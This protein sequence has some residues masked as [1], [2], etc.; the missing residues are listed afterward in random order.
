MVAAPTSGRQ[1]GVVPVGRALRRRWNRI[2]RRLRESELAP[3]L[4]LAS[5]SVLIGAGQYAAPTVVPLTALLIPLIIGNLVL[6]PRTLPWTVVFG[7]GVLVVVVAST[8]SLLDGRRIGGVVV[9]FL[10]GLII[11]VSSFRRTRLGVA[12]VRGESM[13]VDLRDRI[14]NQ[15]RMPELPPDWYAEVVLRSAGGSSFAGDFLVASRAEDGT[16][17]QVAVVDVSGKGEQAG[18]RS[19]LLSGAFGGLLGALPAERFLVAANDYLLRQDWSEGFATAVHAQ[20]DLRTGVFELR[21]AGHPPGVQMHAGSGRW[22]VHEAEG[23]VLGLMK[24]AEFTVVHGRVDRGDALLLF[25]DGVVETPQR[26]I[27][28]GIDKLLGLGEQLLRS[29]FEQ[30]AHR[31]LDRLGSMHDDDRALLLLHRR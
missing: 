27:S 16:S 6:S 23:P 4:L 1:T 18:S 31:L 26:D 25:T 14:H 22:E 15:A 28:L 7:L 19:L 30:G 29:G 20:I 24:D 8:A 2:M 12:G 3:A 21:S 5:S 17:M 13:L 10:I 11:L 9:I